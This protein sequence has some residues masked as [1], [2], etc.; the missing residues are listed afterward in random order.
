MSRLD[1]PV[2]DQ[3]STHVRLWLVNLS[4]LQALYGS[5][6][7]TFVLNTVQQRLQDCGLG[8]DEISIQGDFVLIALNQLRK[9]NHFQRTHPNALAQLFG[10]ALE[11][12]PISQDNIRIYLHTQVA[13]HYDSHPYDTDALPPAGSQPL[14]PSSSRYSGRLAQGLGQDLPRRY[15]LSGNDAR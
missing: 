13:Y 8:A 1:L 4:Y 3:C 6:F 12:D 15:E 5:S 9:Q 2:I 14:L 7:H 11:C 10:A